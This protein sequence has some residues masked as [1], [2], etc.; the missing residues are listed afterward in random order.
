M[1]DEIILQLCCGNRETLLFV[2]RRSSPF[3]CRH[4]WRDHSGGACNEG[5]SYVFSLYKYTLCW[6]LNFSAGARG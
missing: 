6:V 4:Q 5:V 2:R 1:F 3:L